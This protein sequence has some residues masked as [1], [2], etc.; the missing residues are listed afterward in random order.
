MDSVKKEGIK[1]MTLNKRFFSILEDFVNEYKIAKSHPDIIEYSD[2]LIHTETEYKNLEKDMFLQKNH[3]EQLVIQMNVRIR[4]QSKNIDDY[5]KSVEKLKKKSLYLKP[6]VN[7][8]EGLYEEEKQ[9]YSMIHY[10]I[11]ALI[12]GVFMASGLIYTTFRKT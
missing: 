2:K 10:E 5:R 4:N 12:M 1:N 3:L 6:I 8:S 11:V 9:L 7:S